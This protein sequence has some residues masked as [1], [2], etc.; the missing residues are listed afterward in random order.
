MESQ[1]KQSRESIDPNSLESLEGGLKRAQQ[2]LSDME[3]DL[4]NRRYPNGVPEEYHVRMDELKEDIV[5]FEDA[6]DDLKRDSNPSETE[7]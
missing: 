1:P 5:R 4:K 6:I 3:Y 7:R 2:K